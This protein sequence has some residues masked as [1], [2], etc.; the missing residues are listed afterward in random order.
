[1]FGSYIKT[2]ENLRFNSFKVLLA[3]WILFH[4]LRSL[5]VFD[6]EMLRSVVSDYILETYPW[7]WLVA[8]LFVDSSWSSKGVSIFWLVLLCCLCLLLENR[9]ID[10]LPLRLVFAHDH[11]FSNYISCNRPHIRQDKLAVNYPIHLNLLA[12]L[13]CRWYVSGDITICSKRA[14]SLLLL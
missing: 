1:M 10:E 5:I 3:W 8:A 4:F 6:W 2:V 7:R 9:Q 11:F 13:I 12:T 14:R